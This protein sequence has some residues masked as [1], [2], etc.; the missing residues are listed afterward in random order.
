MKRDAWTSSFNA[1]IYALDFPEVEVESPSQPEQPP[2]TVVQIPDTNLRAAIAETLS[3]NPNVPITVEEMAKLERLDVRNRRIQDLT[4][5]Q[6][7]T[8]LSQLL[9]NDNQISDIS[10]I[11][12]LTELWQ[13]QIERNT[14]SDISP[15]RD[16]KNLTFLNFRRN[17]ISDISPIAA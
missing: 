12:G 10:P 14:I 9:L 11:S 1:M 8:N 15:V 3:K 5:L 7:A 17:Q 6:F 13:L 2:G 16:L 4:G